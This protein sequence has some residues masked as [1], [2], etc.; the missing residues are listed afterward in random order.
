[1][2]RIAIIFMFFAYLAI[3]DASPLVAASPPPLRPHKNRHHKPGRRLHP[4][5]RPTPD[6]LY[7]M[8]HWWCD[9]VP[10]SAACVR[11]HFHAMESKDRAEAAAKHREARREGERDDVDAMHRAWCLHVPSLKGGNFGGL[12]S[13]PCRAWLWTRGMHADEL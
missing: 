9:Q 11:K 5:D 13:A 10:D 4:R 2:K 7:K 8:E 6:E 3:A 12:A 1:M